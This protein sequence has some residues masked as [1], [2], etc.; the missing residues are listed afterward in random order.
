MLMIR[1]TSVFFKRLLLETSDYLKDDC[2]KII[3]IVEIVVSAVDCPRLQHSIKVPE[4]FVR[5]SITWKVQTLSSMWLE[6]SFM[7]ISWC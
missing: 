5:Y 2:L 6:K 4:S 3:C 1:D 7:P